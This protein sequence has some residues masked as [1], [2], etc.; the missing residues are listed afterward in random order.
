VRNDRRWRL[1]DA[2]RFAV[3]IAVAISLFL[4]A[5]SWGMKGPELVLV[6]AVIL[7][8]AGLGVFLLGLRYTSLA[9]VQTTAQVLTVSKPPLR[10]N[11]VGRCEMR[12]HVE[13]DGV[14]RIVKVRVRGVPVLKWPRPGMD[15]PVEVSRRN[16]RQ[17]RIRWDAV[18]AVRLAPMTPGEMA[19]VYAP[20]FFTDYVDGSPWPD[21]QA[22]GPPGDVPATT[23]GGG[24][25]GA[26]PTVIGPRSDAVWMEDL[27]EEA[28]RGYEEARASEGERQSFSKLARETMPDVSKLARE[29]MPDVSKLTSETTPDVWRGLVL[30]G[31][32]VLSNTETSA[33]AVRPDPVEVPPDTVEVPPDSDDVPRLPVRTVPHPRLGDRAGEATPQAMG[34]MLIVSNLDRSV[35]FFRDVLEFAIVDQNAGSA[36]LAYGGGRVLLRRVADMSPVDRRVVHLHINVPDVDSAYARLRGKGVEFLRR[37]AV[38]NRGDRLELWAA[39]LRDPDGHAIALTQWRPRP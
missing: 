15:L 6:A 35:S 36:V 26:T 11:I 37:P 19:A 20:P 21:E 16:P 14:A 29:T 39:T 8:V 24:P 23:G 30:D 2:Q 22:E 27:S 17:L 34:V 32:L 10:N 33:W 25:T 4:S 5:M 13:V 12:L 31:E 28:G 1:T 9:P 38:V 7:V 18:P 3:V